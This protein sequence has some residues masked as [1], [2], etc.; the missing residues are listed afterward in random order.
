[1]EDKNMVKLTDNH[2]EA[3]SLIG[4]GTL[5]PAQVESVLDIFSATNE[6]V[7]DRCYIAGSLEQVSF[8]A[9]AHVDSKMV[10]IASSNSEGTADI[11]R[12]TNMFLWSDTTKKLSNKLTVGHDDF[13]YCIA[14]ESD[15]KDVFGA[16]FFRVSRT[17]YEIID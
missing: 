3:L 1:M 5:T 2:V 12:V 9:Y 10:C 11:T 15:K 16:F 14:F 8:V 17:P 6:W 4:T 7:T 13:D